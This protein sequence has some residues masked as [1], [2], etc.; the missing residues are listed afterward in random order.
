LFTVPFKAGDSG[1][2]IFRIPAIWAS[3]NKPLLA[4][5][6]GRVGKRRAAGNIDIVLRRSLDQGQTWEPLQVVVDMGDD[7]CGNPCIVQDPSNS[8][9]WLAFTRSP[10]AATEEEIV[11][12]TSAPTTVWIVHSDDDGATWSAPRDLS[13]T[14]RKASWGW[15]G[16]GPGLGLYLRIAQSGRLL[17]PAYHTDAGIYKTHCLLSDDHGETWRLSD[18]AANDTSEPQVVVMGDHSLVMNARTIAGKGEQRTLVVSRDRGQTWQP[19]SE[20]QALVD[21]HC[22]GCTYRSYRSGTKDEYDLIYSQP[23]N[24]GRVNVTAWL[25]PDD[26]KSWPFAQTLWRGPSAYTAMIRTHDG[27][28]CMLLE[29]GRADTFEQIAFVKFSQ[30][31]LRT[32]KAP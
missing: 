26:G 31:W 6:E 2:L 21:N 29:C 18:V 11:G 28:I 8:R 14:C 5:A 22:Q 24:R 13:A 12:G 9:L 32:R 27:Q 4:I 1:Y 17:I 25:S 30:E 20:I 16:T 19:A 23:I 10:G 7:F 3:P 15:Y